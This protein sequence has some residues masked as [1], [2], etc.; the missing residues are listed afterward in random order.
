MFPGLPARSSLPDVYQGVKPN[1]YRPSNPFVPTDEPDWIESPSA[2]LARPMEEMRS[3]IQAGDTLRPTSEADAGTLLNRGIDRKSAPSVPRKPLS[4]MV[5]HQSSAP[6][7]VHSRS[8]MIETSFPPPPRRLNARGQVARYLEHAPH[9][10]QNHERRAQENRDE[11]STSPPLPL[12]PRMKSADID[13]VI[14][15]QGD[16]LTSIPSLQPQQPG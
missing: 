10:Q 1:P 11:F 2:I 3:L 9:A 16:G 14:D 4:L 6:A 15:S 8:R 12:K 13:S 5:Q 7:P